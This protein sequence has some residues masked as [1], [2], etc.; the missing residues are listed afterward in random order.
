MSSPIL[1]VN[2]V[3]ASFGDKPIISGVTFEVTEGETLAIIGP[4]GAG[5]TVLFKTL[6]GS[7]PHSGSIE[8]AKSARIGYVPQT[9]D[10]ERGLPLTLGDFLFTKARLLGLGA[11]S[12]E[13]S[14]RLVHLSSELLTHKLGALSGGQLQRGLIAFALLGDPNV[15]L[16]DEPTAGIDAPREEQIYDTIHRLQDERKLTIILISHDLS[17][18]YSHSTSVLCLN[19]QVVC[20]G[21]PHHVLTPENLKHLYGERV[22]YHHIH[23]SHQD[24]NKEVSK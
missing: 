8:W 23:G 11:S 9:I 13:E 3:G 14:L 12:V 16:L 15:L 22:L 19:Q 10:L 6:I 24:E 18:V 4:N 2:N 1:Q 20:H 17:L 7:L 5:K 21:A